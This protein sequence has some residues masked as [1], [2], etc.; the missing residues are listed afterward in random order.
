MRLIGCGVGP[1]KGVPYPL[2]SYHLPT[3]RDTHAT[4]QEAEVKG[5]PGG[6]GPRG[7]DRDLEALPG[8]ANTRKEWP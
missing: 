2:E 8:P 6:R 1:P 5:G 7:G 3:L 4:E